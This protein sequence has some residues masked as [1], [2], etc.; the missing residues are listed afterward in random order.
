MIPPLRNQVLAGKCGARDEGLLLFGSGAPW[1]PSEMEPG[2]LCGPRGTPTPAL[3]ASGRGRARGRVPL[4]VLLGGESH[5]P[6]KR[7]VVLRGWEQDLRGAEQACGRAAGTGQQQAGEQ[8]QRFPPRSSAWGCGTL[9]FSGQGRDDGQ[10]QE[11]L[12][13]GHFQQCAA[14]GA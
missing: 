7:A 8:L 10:G 14:R 2:R 5:R 4:W 13:G 6:P 3:C 9:T 12:Q 1:A 11:G